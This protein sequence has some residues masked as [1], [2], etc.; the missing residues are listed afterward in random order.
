[1]RQRRRPYLLLVVALALAAC[2]SAGPSTQGSSPPEP[3]TGGPAQASTGFT[4]LDPL[5]DRATHTASLL[6]DGRVIVVGGCVIDGCGQAT[7][8]TEIF[9]P[10]S[11]RFARV[12]STEIHAPRTD[13]WVTGPRLDEARFKHAAVALPDGSILIVGGTTDDDVLLTSIEGY[14]GSSFQPA[15]LLAEAR[16][17]F[18]CPWPEAA[19]QSCGFPRTCRCW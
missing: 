4:I 17:R 1:M 11:G 2:T 7:A 18:L 16:S 10:S 14:D 8:S 9:D 6:P 19:T 5:V 3:S 12:D 15:G 13:S